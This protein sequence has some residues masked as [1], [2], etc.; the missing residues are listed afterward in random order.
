MVVF[1]ITAPLIIGRL[2]VDMNHMRYGNQSKSVTS[3]EC[4]YEESCVGT[5]T[6]VAQSCVCYLGGV[7]MCV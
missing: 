4:C 1:P 7:C 3:G 6:E 5:P 2:D